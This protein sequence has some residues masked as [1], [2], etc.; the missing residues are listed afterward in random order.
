MGKPAYGHKTHRCHARFSCFLYKI[1]TLSGTMA[2]FESYQC[3]AGDDLGGRVARRS[4]RRLHA[5]E[6][7][8]D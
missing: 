1:I 5:S 4:C 2:L 3:L 7:G 6:E 8:V